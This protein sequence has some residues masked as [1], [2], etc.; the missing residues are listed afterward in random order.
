MAKEGKMGVRQIR[1]PAER[2]LAAGIALAVV[3]AACGAVEP[4]LRVPPEVV[5]V[6]VKPDSLFLIDNAAHGVQLSVE[7]V[8]TGNASREVRWFSTDTAVAS[9]DQSGVVRGRRI[10]WTGIGAASIVDTA[11]ADTSVVAVVEAVK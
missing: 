11:I 5:S 2:P 6:D 9:V 1:G 3:T 10:G 8:T 7:V 4:P